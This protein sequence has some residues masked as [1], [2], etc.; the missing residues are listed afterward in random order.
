MTLSKI[1]L[2]IIDE[3]KQGINVSITGPAGTG[4]TF[5]IDY[6]KQELGVR[7]ICVTAA[8]GVAAS[9]IQGTTLHSWA[10]IGLGLATAKT[11]V[12]QIKGGGKQ[13]WLTTKVLIIDEISMIPAE[14]MDKLNY[15]GQTIRKC[16]LPFG[17]IQLVCI[18]DFLQLP[19]V[20]NGLER[21]K[22]AFE[23]DAWKEAKFKEFK[24]TENFRQHDPEFIQ[25]LSELREGK[26]SPVSLTFL[27]SCSSKELKVDNGIIPTKLYCTREDVDKENRLEL[28]KIQEPEYVFHAKDYG[29]Q[30]KL[31]KCMWPV[32]LKLKKGAQVMYLRND[33]E[34]GLV[35]GSR[36]IVVDFHRSMEILIGPLVLFENQKHP[37]IV[38]SQDF[39]IEQGEKCLARRH[40]L[41]LQLAWALTVHKAQGLTLNQAKINVSKA[42]ECAQIY[43][44]ISR[45][46]SPAG[47]SLIGF[48]PQ[49]VVASKKALQFS[50]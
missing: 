24:L 37:Q 46:R 9:L 30:T 33:S 31:E 45:V 35:N 16:E 38:I 6:L 29:D 39:K 44:A 26:C 10:G 47:L 8:T 21:A 23:A 5:M 18:G 36:G 13:R 28:A 15:V 20:S 32:E 11:L 50:K 43:V 22:F 49:K 25:V 27:R 12:K 41:P 14:L 7:G 2:G 42:F 40:Q 4:K 34:A 1:Q 19:P 48:D 3:I 17:G